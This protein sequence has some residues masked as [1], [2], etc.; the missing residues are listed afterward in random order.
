MGFV[1]ES[2]ESVNF[3]NPIILILKLDLEML[4]IYLHTKNE[5]PM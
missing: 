3:P 4:N 2:L 5:V 1:A